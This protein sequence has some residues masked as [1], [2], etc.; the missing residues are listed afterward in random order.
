MERKKAPHGEDAESNTWFKNF[1]APM[2]GGLSG[3]L[4]RAL[5]QP[6]DCIKVRHQLQLEPI[7]KDAG[8]KYTSTMQTLLL[9]FKEEGVKGLWKGHVPGQI[10]SV[11]YG[12]G[13]FFAYD[14]FNRHS[15]S[16]KFFNDHSDVRHIVG[17]GIAGAFGMSIATPFDVVRTRFI[18]QDSN[19][20]YKNLLEAFT[21][22]TRNEG[23]R[24][25]FRGLVPGISAIAPNAAIQ[26][27]TY[28]FLLEKYAT[29]MNQEQASRHVV[30]LA[31][32]IS[33]I[34]AK[35]CIYPLDLTKKRLQ[36]QQ[37]HGSRTTFGKNI[38]T[39]GMIDC[40]R[41]TLREEQIVGLYKG[42]APAV[43]KSGAMSGFYFFFFEEI[44]TELNKL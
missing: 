27:G 33:G 44:L 15:R 12:F 40:L 43:I 18:A 17:G 2:A 29:F 5:T 24:G 23:L 13:Q 7:K 41:Q 26:F 16:I 4:T 37:F 35:S 11:T 8:A 9:M 25:L 38:T 28:N 6:L 3:F 22:I 1:K 14:Q 32:M 39:S 19:G 36:I 31:G 21:S 20:G 10:L 42:W 34:I 30:L